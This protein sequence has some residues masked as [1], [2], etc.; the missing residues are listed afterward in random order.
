MVTLHN[1]HHTIQTE[2]TYIA[3]KAYFARAQELDMSCALVEIVGDR[4]NIL[5]LDDR[6]VFL[7]D[8]E[9][10]RIRTGKQV[11][12]GCDMDVRKCSAFHSAIFC[13]N[14]SESGTEWLEMISWRER[15][16]VSKT[17]ESVETI[18][19]SIRLP[20]VRFCEVMIDT[21]SPASD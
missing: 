17:C 6:A 21:F 8:G 12:C 18:A 15:W 7:P 11:L 9:V 5:V 20:R 16:K 14:S 3:Y 13:L 2:D 10:Y 1:D 4:D 19:D